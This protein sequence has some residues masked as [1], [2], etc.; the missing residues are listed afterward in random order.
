MRDEEH[1]GGDAAGQRMGARPRHTPGSMGAGHR[2]HPAL[3]HAE[4]G[5]SSESTALRQK[6]APQRRDQPGS[7]Y[8]WRNH[9][10]TN[11]P[12]HD[13]LPAGTPFPASN[14]PP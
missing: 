8:V 10:R 1:L 3:L 13:P 2:T 6:R 5:M 14:R 11:V 7:G 4:P 12:P 9:V